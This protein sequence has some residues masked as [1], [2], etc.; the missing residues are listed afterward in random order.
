MFRL[1]KYALLTFQF[2]GILASVFLA[3][4]TYLNSSQVE[5]RLQSFAIEK[6][7]VAADA[8]WVHASDALDH[9][10]RAERLS[11]LA[12]RFGLQAE[13]LDQKREVIVPVLVA[14]ALSDRCGDNCGFAARAG[15]VVNSA[16][17]GQ[18]AKLRVGQSTLGDFIVERYET[19][20]RGLLL[21]LRRFGLVNV[22]T[23]ALMS[24]LIIFKGILNWRFA[25]LSVGVT[26]YAT[27]AAYGYIYKQDWARTVLLQNW[28]ADGYQ[29]A[30][31]VVCCLFFDWLFLRGKVSEM[32]AASIGAIFSG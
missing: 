5:D 4:V 11:A 12:E 14:Y 17:L 9:G 24:A 7:K 22:V 6:V 21:D 1:G 15:P 19:T 20:V 18:I 27:W 16:M 29:V 26:G 8:A 28:A 13:A 31:I 2:V 25:A 32:V 3:G 10:D 23:L 30:M